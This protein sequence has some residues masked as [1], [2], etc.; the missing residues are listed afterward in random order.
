MQLNPLKIESG[1][2][3]AADSVTISVGLLDSFIVRFDS[4]D[5]ELKIAQVNIDKMEALAKE[6][7]SA[8]D[9]LFNKWYVWGGFF[10]LGFGTG[11]Y[12]GR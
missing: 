10:V 5:M 3:C 11:Y 6:Q 4:L 9:S 1:T 7:D 8:W 12:A 2:A